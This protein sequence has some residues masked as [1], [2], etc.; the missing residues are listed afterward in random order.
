MLGLGW[1][2]SLAILGGLALYA[3]FLLDPQPAFAY[4]V[5]VNR[6]S[7]YDDMP[8]PAAAGR[9]L[10]ADIERRLDASPLNDHAPHAIFVTNTAWR[11]DLAF[12]TEP[13]AAGVNFA[14]LTH[15]VFIRRA[16]IERDRIVGASGREPQ[17]PRTLAYYAAHE[18]AHTLTSERQGAGRLWNRTL[19]QWVREGYADY[20]GIGRRGEVTELYG[21]LAAGDPA[22]DYRRSGQYAGF[23]LLVAYYLEIRGWSV[24]N[25]L[26]TAPSEDDAR[27]TMLSDGRM[28]R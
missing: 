28:R 22:L 7:L 23:R 9:A 20:V 13:S 11:R 8:F 5:S 16:D 27:R 2:A 26:N 21:R 4:H 18:I 25:L 10:L 1:S 3:A 19:P 15:N 12:M 24:D 6:L 14:P 17:P